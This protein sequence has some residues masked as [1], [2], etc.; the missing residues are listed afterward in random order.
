MRN[1]IVVLMVMLI[2]FAQAIAFAN[3]G[4]VK[5]GVQITDKTYKE[6]YSVGDTF[7][8]KITIDEACDKLGSLVGSIKFDAKEIEITNTQEDGI[9][10]IEDG[11]VEGYITPKYVGQGEE[12]Y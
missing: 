5:I 3:S 7:V 8:V 6:K 10:I 4:V 12:K 1:K 2:C 9:E 11:E